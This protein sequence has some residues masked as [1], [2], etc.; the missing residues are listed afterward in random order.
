MLSSAGKPVVKACP[1]PSV[2]EDG[3]WTG[4]IVGS[5]ENR[6]DICEEKELL[7]QVEGAWC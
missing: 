2:L 5:V 6:N 7:E 1:M 4:L 3:G